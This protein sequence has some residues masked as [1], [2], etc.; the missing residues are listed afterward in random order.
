MKKEKIIASRELKYVVGC[1]INNIPHFI[2]RDLMG[3]YILV[4]D[5]ALS[6]KCV[7]KQTAKELLMSYKFDIGTSYNFVILPIEVTY[8]I[9]ESEGDYS[10]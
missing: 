7:T 3:R 1:V 8:E 10:G 4:A 9:L 6:T 2:R 5:V